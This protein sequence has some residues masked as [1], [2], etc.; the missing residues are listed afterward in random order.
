MTL[1]H[2]LMQSGILL[3]GVFCSYCLIKDLLYLFKKEKPHYSSDTTEAGQ[4][5][6]TYCRSDNNKE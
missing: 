4:E 3:V 2:I 5:E 6:K 1:T